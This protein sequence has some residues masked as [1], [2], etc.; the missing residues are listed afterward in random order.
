MS[1]CEFK[2]N[3]PKGVLK[4]VQMP[5]GSFEMEIE[6]RPGFEHEM[7]QKF[8]NVQQIIDSEVLRMC[9]PYVPFDTGI[10]KQSGIMNTEIGSGAVIYRTPY[11]RKQYYVP[12]N[13]NEKRCAYWFE[14]M[15]NDGGKEKILSAAKK[16]VGK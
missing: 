6:W 10:L 14:Q 16:V 15:K 4:K 7:E 8:Q 9:D 13:H 5:N 2:I 1:A 11:A 3:T 12:M